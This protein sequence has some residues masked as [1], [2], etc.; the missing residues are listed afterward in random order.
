MS[1]RADAGWIRVADKVFGGLLWLF[2]KPLREAHGE[3]MRQA[4]RDRCREVARGERSA[5]RVLAMELLPDTLRSA[6][7]EQWS[8]S[9]DQM[10]RR[11]LLALGLL[12]CAALGLLMQDRFGPPV[13]N[14]LVSMRDGVSELREARAMQ[15]REQQVQRVAD[16]LQSQKTAEASA[17]AAFLERSLYTHRTHYLIH[18]DANTDGALFMGKLPAYGVQA[19]ALAA[20]VLTGKPD[21]YPLTVAVQA[22]EL[23][24]GCDR[25]SAIRDL[26]ARDPD[27]GYGWSLAFKWASLHNDEG[28]MQSALGHLAAA[29]H[30]ES[31]RGRIFSDL[32]A[33][34]NRL[35]PDDV[36]LRT[37]M[38]M[39]V[40]D[41][42]YLDSE[43]FGSDV[44]LHCTAR[45]DGRLSGQL[46]RW[47]DRH[48]ESEAE[49]VAVAKLLSRTSDLTSSRW[50]TH[51]LNKDTT[52]AE[53]WLVGI[54][55][56]PSRSR[57]AWRPWT[58]AEWAQWSAAWAP[59][60]GEVPAM[61]RW[62]ATRSPAQRAAAE[63]FSRP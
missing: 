21:L 17:L 30:Y 14:W 18:G 38:A 16:A 36:S 10:G 60:D 9:F 47:I 59:G 40:N 25:A 35:A 53:T 3:E 48:P 22:C 8:A 49:C 5:F 50:G 4:F 51:R 23:S 11:Q 61:H 32:F 20:G 42:L 1:R 26:L 58:D 46:V 15:Q 2:P 37:A 7:H 33:A 43:D 12:C 13:V 19:T 56:T 54:V 6:G 52:Q 45:P 28:A 39:Q 31:F 41:S 62:L 24:A 29:T 55:P 44:R 57:Y 63:A 27:N 34:A